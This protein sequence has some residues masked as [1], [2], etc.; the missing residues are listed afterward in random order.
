MSDKTSFNFSRFV[1]F[2][3]SFWGSL[4]ILSTSLP[5]IIYLLKTDL[6]KSSVI[7]E[8]YVSIPTTFC[9]LVIPFTFLFEDKL[10]SI[11][12]ARSKSILFILLALMFSFGFLYIKT[13]K[14]LDGTRITSPN[15]TLKVGSSTDST[16]GTLRKI[17]TIEKNTAKNGAVKVREFSCE[18]GVE[19]GSKDYIND[20]ELLSVTLYTFSI[21]FT[22]ISFSCLGIFYYSNSKPRA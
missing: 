15:P 22:T 12:R 5:A 14:V 2:L 1:V 21:L 11:S 20:L 13:N 16:Y 3:K 4:A 8:Y 10:S 17:C 18:G 6:I 19:I 7:A 9:L